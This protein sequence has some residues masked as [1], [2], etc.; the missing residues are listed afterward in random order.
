MER[1]ADDRRKQKSVAIDV[2]THRG[3]SAEND[4]GGDNNDD[5]KDDDDI[6]GVILSPVFRVFSCYSYLSFKF[7]F[8]SLYCTIQLH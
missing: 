4:V 8:T 5:D 6:F 1:S 2:Q 3:Y 7:R